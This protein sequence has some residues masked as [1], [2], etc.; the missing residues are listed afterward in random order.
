[1]LMLLSVDGLDY[2]LIKSMGIS[3]FKYDKKMEIPIECYIMSAGRL[4]PHTT[5]VWASIFSGTIIDY[6]SIRREG[7]RLKVHDFLVKNKVTWRRRSDISAY[8]INPYNKDLDLIFNYYH[9]FN[10]NCPTISPEWIMM[11][12]TYE[13]FEQYCKRELLM[14]FMMSIGGTE[15]LFDLCS[16][17]TRFID[18]I[19]H[20]KPH[21]LDMYYHAIFNH[22]NQLIDH[23]DMDVILLSDHGTIEGIHTDYAYIGSNHPIMA[24]SIED[25]RHDFE[26][27]LE[28]KGVERT[29]P[30]I[31]DSE[32][33]KEEEEVIKNRLRRLGYIE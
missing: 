8:R 24:D 5:R 16:F 22:A 10:W 3:K 31:P 30:Y 13:L 4:T 21:E 20:N 11:F 27:I 18:Y 33:S 2:E 32:Y 7:L 17:Y 28:L 29:E 25:L 15:Q 14:W 1:M 6:S 26:R 19:G 9:S 23:Y 12:P